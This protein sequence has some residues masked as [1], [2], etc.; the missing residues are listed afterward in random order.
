MGLSALSR[1]L[2]SSETSLGCS[3]TKMR[4][5]S[6]R[7]GKWKVSHFLLQEKFRE[8]TGSA[9]TKEHMKVAEEEEQEG[10]RESGGANLGGGNGGECKEVR[11]GAVGRGEDETLP[12]CVEAWLQNGRR[13]R[14]VCS[15]INELYSSPL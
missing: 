14:P 1:W 8:E 11:C 4:R 15:S 3:F 2:S 7:G 6:D 13:F 9:P 12:G 5:L 10:K